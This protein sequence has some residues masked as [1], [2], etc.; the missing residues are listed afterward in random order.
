[1]PG[2]VSIGTATD[3]EW[4]DWTGQQYSNIVNGGEKE[5]QDTQ[6]M[7]NTY[8]I[9]RVTAEELDFAKINNHL[10]DMSRDIA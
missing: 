4:L 3:T 2:Q 8:R 7:S 5:Q 6:P 1:M 10:Q 9:F